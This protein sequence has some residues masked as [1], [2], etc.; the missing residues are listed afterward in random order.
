MAGLVDDEMAWQT[1]RAGVGRAGA[2]RAGC[3]PKRHQLE[4]AGQL[5]WKRPVANNGE[6]DDTVNVWTTGREA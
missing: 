6:P 1:A 5:L 3:V 4:S 2:I